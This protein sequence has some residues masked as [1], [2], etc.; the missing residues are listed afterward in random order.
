MSRE[1]P[2]PQHQPAT[3]PSGW[4]KSPGSLATDPCFLR[5]DSSLRLAA[6]GLYTGAIGWILAHDAVEG[7]IPEAALLFGQVCAAPSDQLATVSA[8][9][10][11][12]GIFAA[13]NLDGMN[14]FVVAGG[15]KALNDRF[16]RQK[17]A[18]TAGKASAE[19]QATS[20]SST[21]SKYPGRPP[22]IDPDKKV[23]WSQVDEAL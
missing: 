16:A 8:E 2:Q 14:G 5:V 17:S 21:P 1:L 7:W 18:S 19:A 13:V 9:L 12:A 22:R 3:P 20:R 23:D 6:V 10:V 4:W 11:K 15:V